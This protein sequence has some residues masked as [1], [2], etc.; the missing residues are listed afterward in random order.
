MFRVTI[1]QYDGATTLR[2]PPLAAGLLAATLVDALL[3][4][5]SPR[6]AAIRA[7]LARFSAA[8]VEAR[9]TTLPVDGWGPRRRE[10]IDAACA[11][12]LDDPAG[13]YAEAAEVAAALAGDDAALIRDVVAWDALQLPST[14]ADL[15]AIPTTAEFAHDWPAYAAQMGSRPRPEPR[16]I[17]VRAIPWPL[18]V[19]RAARL[20]AFV[21]L[22]WAK[23]PRGQIERLP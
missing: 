23:Q 21:A 4:A 15:D 11:R 10:P 7:E 9:A 8:V 19:E 20:D 1:A 2:A 3:A 16:R 12:V 18:A 22:G 5:T 14:A 13:F 17:A 6:L